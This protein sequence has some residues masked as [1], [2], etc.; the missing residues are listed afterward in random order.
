MKE[1]E[2]QKQKR[3]KNFNS[4]QK[5]HSDLC[6]GKWR[7]DHY[8]DEDWQSIQSYQSFIQIRVWGRRRFGFFLKKVIEYYKNKYIKSHE[9]TKEKLHFYDNY[10]RDPYLKKSVHYDLLSNETKAIIKETNRWDKKTVG[11]KD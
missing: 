11:N 7:S 4:S 8:Q 6:E 5:N 10:E 3:G 1:T 9:K 2:A